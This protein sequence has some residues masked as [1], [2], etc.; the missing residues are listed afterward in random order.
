[1]AVVAS[2][3]SRLQ[4]MVMLS[5]AIAACQPASCCPVLKT[6]EVGTTARFRHIRM[7][8][9]EGSTVHPG[10]CASMSTPAVAAAAE[11]PTDVAWLTTLTPS[12]WASATAA[13]SAAAE[14]WW[15][16]PSS[17]VTGS[18]MSSAP[19]SLMRARTTAAA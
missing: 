5:S 2:M 17:A 7:F 6:P 18:L 3:A 15:S 8:T 10:R 4:R 13:A 19:W 11:N 1:M 16:V 14:S 9:S 12:A